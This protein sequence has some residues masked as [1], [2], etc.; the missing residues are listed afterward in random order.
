MGKQP[1]KGQKMFD[2]N[3]FHIYLW[4]AGSDWYIAFTV[5]DWGKNV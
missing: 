1:L 5:T 4:L 2:E 3:I